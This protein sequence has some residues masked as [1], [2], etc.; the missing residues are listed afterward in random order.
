M[1]D[2][3]LINILVVE[4][5]I[6]INRMLAAFF[7]KN[8]FTAHSA[9][10]GTDALKKIEKQTFDIIILDLLLPGL[11]GEEL[12]RIVRDEP[13]NIQTPIIVLSAKDRIPSLSHTLSIGA[14][15]Y[16]SKPY[17]E[18]E[19]LARVEV[20]LRRSKKLQKEH[21]NFIEIKKLILD[22]ET[23][24][25]ICN[26]N[27]IDLTNTEYNILCLFMT[28]PKTIHRYADIIET[29]WGLDTDIG[30]NTLNVHISNIRKK[31]HVANP[32]EKYIKTC[33]GRGF[34]METNGN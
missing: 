1:K 26:G 18:S 3:K 20:H 11:T 2:S 31:L 32:N 29:V 28:S 17:D 13:M 7:T 12:L 33:H 10:N 30:D 23:H 19:L 22:T 24:E 27:M 6:E 16:I 25:V 5:E 21:T 34:S 9:Y 14:D 4:D 15:D 8:G